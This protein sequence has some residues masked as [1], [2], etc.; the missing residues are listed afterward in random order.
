MIFGEYIQKRL[1]KISVI[2]VL[3]ISTISY[4]GS[5]TF[6]SGTGFFIND[7]GYI[8]TASHVV[9]GC[10]KIYVRNST[11]KFIPAI[12][13]AREKKHDIALL[14]ANIT[15]RDTAIFK[16][17]DF[18]DRA[19]R[20]GDNLMVIGY[21]LDS[22][23]NGIYQVAEA[24]VVG[25]KGR[26]NEPNYI[27]FSNSA[28]QGN[29]GGPLLD[30][31]GKVIG[32]VTSK[33]I[34]SQKNMY[35]DEKKIIEQVDIATNFATIKRFLNRNRIYFRYFTSEGYFSKW[36]IEN[37]ARHYIVNIRCVEGINYK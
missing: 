5:Y 15:P 26:K 19:L 32:L 6:K 28:K 14:Q 3:V 24:R 1:L 27:Q 12:L 31:S 37:Q 25:L 8:L 21:P 4:A 10:K 11:M 36:D 22:G 23:V 18:T 29:S 7:Q 2:A 34:V 35:N 9:S 33:I 17:N 13:I 30:E 16:A 20:K